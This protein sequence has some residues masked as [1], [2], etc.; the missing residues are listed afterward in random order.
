MV[1]TLLRN[2][3]DVPLMVLVSGRPEMHDLFPNAW[4]HRGI[5]ELRLSELT[6][7]AAERLVREVLGDGVAEETVR[8]LVDGAE[9]NPFCLEELIRAESEGKGG[10]IPGSVL[11]VVTARIERLDPAA[12]RVLRAASVFG[13]QFWRGAVAALLGLQRASEAGTWLDYLVEREVVVRRGRGKFPGEDEYVF[14]HGLVREAAYAMLTDADRG[15]GHRLA[16]QW[17]VHI[18]RKSVV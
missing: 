10:T 3:R 12:R 13:Q 8:R 17:L 5:V 6:A 9:G 2:L 4:G 16:G 11:A 7:K 15:L 18:D 1:D 14:R